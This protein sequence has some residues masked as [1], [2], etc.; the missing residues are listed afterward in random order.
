MSGPLEGLP[1]QTLSV[2]PGDDRPG[3]WTVSW[4]RRPTKVAYD[5]RGANA[6]D[7]AIRTQQPQSQ[8]ANFD[9]ISSPTG[10]RTTG[11]FAKGPHMDWMATV[12]HRVLVKNLRALTRPQALDTE[13]TVGGSTKAGGTQS[14]ISTQS[15]GIRAVYGHSHQVGQGAT[16]NYG[17]IWRPFW[18]S[19]GT[20]ATVT[21]TVTSDINRVD[22]GHQVLVAGDAEHSVVAEVHNKGVLSPLGTIVRKW[23]DLAGE[24]QTVKGG[25]LGHLPERIA[26][27]LGLISRDSLG[28]ARRTHAGSGASRDGSV[29]TLRRVPGRL[30]RHHRGPEHVREQAAR[31]G[32]RRREPR[33]RTGTGLGQG[34]PGAAPGDDRY[35]F[36]G[37]RP[38]RRPGVEERADRRAERPGPGPARTGGRAGICQAL[39]QDGAGGPQVADRVPQRRDV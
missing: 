37:D 35:G 17:L 6:H 32:D 36:F 31:P 28:G 10:S 9:Q 7:A 30:P 14:K 13:L 12:V 38:D 23:R 20:S 33:G 4:P 34:H 16:G 15:A 11:L 39:A 5:P 8:T 1:Y 24:R 27:Q 22:G 21:R 26:Q 25:W 19:R 3:S 2:L 18:R 29:S